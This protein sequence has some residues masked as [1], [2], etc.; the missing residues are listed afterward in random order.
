[1]SDE[2]I[3]AAANA[4]RDIML[5]PPYVHPQCDIIVMAR[6]YATVA[7]E[8]A[9]NEYV[10]AAMAEISEIVRVARD[11]PDNLIDFIKSNFPSEWGMSKDEH[12]EHLANLPTGSGNVQNKDTVN[13]SWE[14]LE[15]V[16]KALGFYAT[17]NYATPLFDKSDINNVGLPFPDTGHK[18][19][20]ALEILKKAGV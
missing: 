16:K 6:M 5:N 9:D 19:Q 10:R 8:V 11:N 18:A 1:M 2:R 20:Y 3:E 12:G 15:K 13:L 14:D 17:A 4:V 7:L